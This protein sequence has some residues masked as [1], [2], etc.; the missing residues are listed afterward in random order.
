VLR[1]KRYQR[2]LLQIGVFES[3]WSISA[4]FSRSMGRPPQIIF[5]RIVRPVNALQLCRWQYSHK[6]TS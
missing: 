2:I 4:K 5:T 1:L 3:G 6:E